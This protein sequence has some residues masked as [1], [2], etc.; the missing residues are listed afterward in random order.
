MKPLIVGK[1]I[2][3]GYED[4]V[5]AKNLNFTVSEGDYLCILGDNGAGKSTLVKAILNLHEPLEG[6]LDFSFDRSEIGYLPQRSQIQRD[7]PSSVY[8]VVLSGCVNSLKSRFFYDKNDKKRALENMD[9]LEILNLAKQPFALLSGGQQQRVLLARALCAAKK[10]L[11][12]DEPVSGLDSHTSSELY[13]I[14]DNLNKDKMTIIMVTHDVHP[15]LN[16]ANTILHLGKSFFFGK[17]EGYFESEVG[18]KYLEE[19]GHH[20]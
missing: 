17:K 5:V 12:L 7:F 6:N 10:V 14:I 16:S 2:T 20:D 8:E 3:L 9:K 15:A 1:N 18:K 4:Q 13:K 11:L 19:S